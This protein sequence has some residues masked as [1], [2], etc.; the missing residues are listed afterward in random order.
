MPQRLG[1]GRKR[2]AEGKPSLDRLAPDGD[3]SAAT[4]ASAA[5]QMSGTGNTGANNP[6]PNVPG[7]QGIDTAGQSP[8]KRFTP[9]PVRPPRIPPTSLPARVPDQLRSALSEAAKLEP[10]PENPNGTEPHPALPRPNFAIIE[11][12]KLAIADRQQRYRQG[13]RRSRL[14]RDAFEAGA[15]AVDLPGRIS[16]ATAGTVETYQNRGR[17][18]F[19]RYKHERAYNLEMDDIDPL[20]FVIWL[21]GVRP[22]WND[23]TWRG[24]RQAA[25]AFIRT[26]P[27]NNLQ[28]ALAVLESI[29]GDHSSFADPPS[30][31][32]LVASQMEH[33]HFN[34][35]LQALRLQS[36]GEVTSWAIDW[37][38]AGVYVGLHPDEWRL[39]DIEQRPDHPQGETFWLH[40]FNS[41]VPETR[42]NGSFRTIDL[43]KFS[44]EA[45]R[46][47][48]RLVKLARGWTLDGT[49]IVR[50]SEVSKLLSQTAAPLFP[51]MTLHYTLDSLRHQFIA[52]MKTVYRHEELSALIGEMFIDDRASN[53]I[54][55]RRA[56]DDGYISEVPLPLEADVSRFRR[57]LA[58]FRERR[59]FRALREQYKQR[60]K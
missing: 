38:F 29:R 46:A 33:T 25:A 4:P 28:E 40:V 49:F 26:V 39:T 42:L 3:G 17:S 53:Y 48:E 52:N 1:D 30:S 31:E 37:M 27:H 24:N 6:P 32:A 60:N 35:I 10:F 7:S 20:D 16:V 54:N 43:S 56:W 5:T 55:R 47:L 21:E 9:P 59:T 8:V 44:I 45:R 51:R 15:D 18:L 12:V 13:Q 58:I 14:T 36:R 41:R 11:E 34:K 2:S 50:K 57:S 22:F 19:A 23:A